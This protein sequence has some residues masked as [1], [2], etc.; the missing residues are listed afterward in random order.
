MSGLGYEL[1]RFSSRLAICARNKC[2]RKITPLPRFSPPPTKLR[3]YSYTGSYSTGSPNRV[4]PLGRPQLVCL[5][6]RV[7][8][9]AGRAAFFVK[10]LFQVKFLL[11]QCKNISK[12]ESIEISH[13]H[14]KFRSKSP[15]IFFWQN[16]THHAPINSETCEISHQIFPNTKSLARTRTHTRIVMGV[17]Y[18]RD[19]ILDSDKTCWPCW[20]HFVFT[21]V[22]RLLSLFLLFPL[23]RYTTETDLIDL[24]CVTSCMWSA[25]PCRQTRDGSKTGHW[26]QGPQLIQP[27]AQMVLTVL[28]Q[29]MD[30]LSFFC[31][32]NPVHQ[33]IWSIQ[34]LAQ[35]VLTVLYA[36]YGPSELFLSK[37]SSTP[38]NLIHSTT[39][40]D[41]PYIEDH[42]SFFVK[43]IQYISDPFF[44][45]TLT[46]S[47][48][49]VTI[50]IESSELFLS[51]KSRTPMN[52][53][54]PL[55]QMVLTVLYA[56]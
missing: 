4:K 56:M 38:M 20:C 18:G 54:E 25:A 53:I 50:I 43:K 46:C 26:S 21:R 34:P 11:H 15:T 33:W 9:E 23:S 37:K 30:H 10:T 48:T 39:C 17:V 8:V 6:R 5:K 51:E 41:G 44:T 55:A 47:D 31:Q 28:M 3:L 2:C 45:L 7:R 42:L 40:S 16:L 29:C 49:S 14:Q 36:M 52:L 1:L 13:H 35:M 27:L 24:F 12:T 32:K 19:I 22:V